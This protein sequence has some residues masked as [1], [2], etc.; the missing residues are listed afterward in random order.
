M[1]LTTPSKKSQTKNDTKRATITDVTAPSGWTIRLPPAGMSIASPKPS[2]KKSNA[3]KGDAEQTTRFK[4]T[5]GMSP[6]QRNEINLINA[7]LEQGQRT[8]LAKAIAAS[9]MGD[10]AVGGTKEEL[11]VV[12]MVVIPTVTKTKMKK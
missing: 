2:T 5:V 12:R 3:S 6:D 1:S 9:I 10:L 11:L 4:H 7:T 8:R